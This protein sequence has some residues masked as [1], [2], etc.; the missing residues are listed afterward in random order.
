MASIKISELAGSELFSDSETFMDSMRDMTQDELKMR[1]GGGKFK[2]KLSIKGGFF[3]GFF[4]GF[5]FPFFG[6][7]GFPFH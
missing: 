2:F 4:G 7:F 1:G 6:G 5:G 3:P